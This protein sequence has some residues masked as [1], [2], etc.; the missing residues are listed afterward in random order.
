MNKSEMKK[1]ILR[2]HVAILAFSFGTAIIYIS[3]WD[4]I[5]TSIPTQIIPSKQIIHSAENNSPYSILEGTIV[6]IKPY[7]ATFEIPESWITYKP[8]SIEPP[9]NLYLSWQDLNELNNFD[10]NHL[11]GFDIKYAQVMRST[12]PFEN[13]ASHLGSKS[14]GNGNTNDLQTR[15]FVVNLSSQKVAEKIKNQGL[16]KARSIFDEVKLVS[17]NYETWEKQN[18]N[19]FEMGSHTFSYTDIDFY[20]RSFGNKTVVFVFVHGWGFDETIKQI[21][22]SFE[23]KK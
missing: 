6:K 11:H 16:N 9:K 17:E 15:V 8:Y 19:V 23:W 20:Y 12:L 5:K 3:V 21:L 10:Y 18:L 2:F 4:A 22:D 1:Y 7:N 14:W 13:C